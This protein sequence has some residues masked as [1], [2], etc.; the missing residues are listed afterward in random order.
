MVV[1]LTDASDASPSAQ[2]DVAPSTGGVDPDIRGF[3][4]NTEP[5]GRIVAPPCIT[6][7]DFY[8]AKVSS[9][10]KTDSVS[11]TPAPFRRSSPS[12]KTAGNS[13]YSSF[14]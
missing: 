10:E 8:G 3:K 4:K 2:V 1:W 7:R 9:E 14:L 5:S 12:A 6:T 11:S 13:V